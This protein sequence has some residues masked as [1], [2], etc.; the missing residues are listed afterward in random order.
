MHYT[1]TFRRGFENE[2][3]LLQS[4]QPSSQLDYLSSNIRFTVRKQKGIKSGFGGFNFL[5]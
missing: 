2:H 4:T 1:L 3:G 5:C